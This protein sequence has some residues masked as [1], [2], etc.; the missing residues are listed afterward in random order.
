MANFIEERLKSDLRRLSKVYVKTFPFSYAVFTRGPA[1]FMADLAV[2][3]AEIEDNYLAIRAA[4]AAGIVKY[5]NLYGIMPVNGVDEFKSVYFLGRAIEARLLK[6][7]HVRIAQVNMFTMIGLMDEKLQKRG[8]YKNLLTK[9]LT[10]LVRI[11]EFDEQLGKNGAYLIYKCS[12]TAPLH[13]TPAQQ[14][15]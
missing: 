6:E 4:A 10:H 13:T 5:C 9:A 15:L 1:D 3:H 2:Y 7:G 12:S 11:R 14:T 8:V